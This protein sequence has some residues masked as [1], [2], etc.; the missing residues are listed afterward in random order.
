MVDLVVLIGL[1]LVLLDSELE[2][3][4]HFLDGEQVGAVQGWS[5]C[6]SGLSLGQLLV[7]VF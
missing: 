2:G 1:L 4:K 5:H 6:Q 3:Q 7:Y